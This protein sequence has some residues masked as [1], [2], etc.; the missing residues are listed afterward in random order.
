M[1]R[2]ATR[3]RALLPDPPLP[4][5]APFPLSPESSPETQRLRCLVALSALCP[6]PAGDVLL[7]E[8]YSPHLDTYQRLL[9]LDVLSSAAQ[10]MAQPPEQAPRL[11]LPS[12]GGGVPCVVYPSQEAR[13]A[14]TGGSGGRPGLPA[15]A[16][17][18]AGGGALRAGGGQGRTRV[19]GPVALRKRGEA[20]PKTHRNVFADVAL[21]WAAGLLRQVGVSP[22]W[23]CAKTMTH[24]A[25]LARF[26]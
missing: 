14:L 24:I 13:G 25:Q 2:Y 1:G 23:W 6:L 12:R 9:V 3:H 17:A 22:S 15:A 11:E 5:P 10:E 4:S 20:A 18:G 21:R 19:W 8:L 7:A 16:A 26:S